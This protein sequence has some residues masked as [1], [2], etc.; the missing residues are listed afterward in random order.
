METTSHLEFYISLLL[1]MGQ[2]RTNDKTLN[3]DLIRAENIFKER[4]ILVSLNELIFH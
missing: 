3:F 2:E 4:N 1:I